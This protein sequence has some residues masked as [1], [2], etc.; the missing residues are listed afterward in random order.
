MTGLPPIDVTVQPGGGIDVTITSPG[1]HV[2]VVE[3][4]GPVAVTVAVPGLQGA[5]GPPGAQGPAGEPGEPGPPGPGGGGF[6]VHVQ[7][8]AAQ[9]W[10]IVHGLGRRPAAVAVEDEDGNEI[11]AGVAR[12]T[13]D[14]VI[15]TLGAATAGRAHL[16]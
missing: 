8:T 1:G 4:S 9:T 11:D 7:D 12:P 3:Q 16:S 6:H 14:T 5:A 13:L 15:I 2:V 10:T